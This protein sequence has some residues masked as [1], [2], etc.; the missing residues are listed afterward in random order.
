MRARRNTREYLT[1]IAL[2][3]PNVALIAMFTYRP[4]IQNINY[5]RFRCFFN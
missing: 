4:L 3:L 2:V 5:S 1:F